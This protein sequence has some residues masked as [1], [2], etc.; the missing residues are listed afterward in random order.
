MPSSRRPLFCA[1][2]GSRTAPGQ[3]LCDKCLIGLDEKYIESNSAIVEKYT[4]RGIAMAEHYLTCWAEFQRWL[5]DNP[6][7]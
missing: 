3:G 5:T 2:C 7:P 4:R 6:Q 1:N